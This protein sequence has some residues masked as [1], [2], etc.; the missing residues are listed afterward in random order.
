[1][2]ITHYKFSTG[3][4]LLWHVDMSIKHYK[5]S[6]GFDSFW[7]VDVS[8]SL[9]LVLIWFLLW[10]VDVSITLSLVLDLVYFAA[11]KF[12]QGSESSSHNAIFY[13]HI[14]LWCVWSELYFISQ[15][16][17]PALRQSMSTCYRH[18]CMILPYFHIPLWTAKWCLHCYLH[19]C[20]I[21]PY[22]HIIISHPHHPLR[23]SIS[24]IVPSNVYGP[25][26]YPY[27]YFLPTPLHVRQS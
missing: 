7:R 15:S 21:P 4:N 22:F 5:F 24:T 16:P 19:M 11:H 18:V 6:T 20:T 3:F 14:P 27:P 26:F 13:F 2:S 10:R 17:I 1:M 9:N 12:P 8:I 23:H 25:T